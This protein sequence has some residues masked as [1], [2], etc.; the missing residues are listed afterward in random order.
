MVFFIE[1]FSRF[2]KTDFALSGSSCPMGR[3]ETACPSY[4]STSDLGKNSQA[5]LLVTWKFQPAF[6]VWMVP[7]L[8]LPLPL[9]SSSEGLIWRGSTGQGR[10]KGPWSTGGSQPFMSWWVPNVPLVDASRHKA[11]KRQVWPLFCPIQKAHHKGSSGV[12]PSCRR[13]HGAP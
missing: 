8:S 10:W 13:R 9:T 3:K 7:T 12:C 1:P 11:G 4:K 6:S 5:H 2:L